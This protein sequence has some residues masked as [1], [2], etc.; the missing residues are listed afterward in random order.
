MTS[1]HLHFSIDGSW[2]TEH[3]R[4]LVREDRW[5]DALRLLV[6]NLD[7]FTWDDGIA[8]LS[9]R[10]CLVGINN[11][12][13]VD[14]PQD[15]ADLQEYLESLA[16]QY[17]DRYKEGSHYYRPYAVVTMWEEA[18]ARYAMEVVGQRRSS[19]FGRGNET[20]WG[21]A[22][23]L[24]YARNRL[25]DRVES[26]LDFPGKLGGGDVLFERVPAP[27]VWITPKRTAQA[28]LDAFRAANK[29]LENIGPSGARGLRQQAKAHLAVVNAMNTALD[30][31][32]QR[33]V[34]G[35]TGVMTVPEIAEASTERTVHADRAAEALTIARG[36][37]DEEREEREA[38]EEERQRVQR[39]HERVVAQASAPG[40]GGFI[41]LALDGEVRKVPRAPF[42][43]WVLWRTAG[44]HLAHPWQF[45]SS[46]GERMLIDDA[47]HTD[48]LV[49]TD[50]TFLQRDR[51]S[52]FRDGC[53]KARGDAQERLL[54]FKCAVLA[55]RGRVRGRVLHPRPDQ[56]VPPG[57]ILVIPTG[58]PEYTIPALSAGGTGCVITEKGGTL[59]H[60]VQ[61]ALEDGLRIVRVEN[62]LTLYPEGT[63]VTVD[64]ERGEIQVSDAHVRDMW[65]ERP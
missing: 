36:L 48:W 29:F 53:Y 9:G 28:A 14:Q 13:L 43:N 40:G 17:G 51:D 11:L 55:G 3:A 18:D 4:N 24:F 47:Y 42:E 15:D 26:G 22:R 30:E 60:L 23:T 35:S 57:S 54:G 27:P 5:E 44:A 6:E 62:A 39:L 12:E 32:V 64:L 63:P 10:K 38:E 33:G 31:N 46:P 2:L 49:G 37:E 19:A 52:A 56:E 21:R 41:E 34:R 20:A 16:W 25:T 8:V 58:D 7:G 45:V 61:V 59:T 65:G 1:E 50:P